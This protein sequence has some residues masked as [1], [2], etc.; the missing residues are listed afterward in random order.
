[1]TRAH[2]LTVS[3]SWTAASSSRPRTPIGTLLA[4]DEEYRLAVAR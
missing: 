1:M 3:S 4:T 2:P